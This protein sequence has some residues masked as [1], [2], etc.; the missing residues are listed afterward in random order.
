MISLQDL[1]TLAKSGWTPKATKEILE[2]V[3]TSPA[4]QD[5]V[6]EKNEDD[7]EIK[8]EEPAVEEEK[9]ETISDQNDNDLLE[10]LKNL[11]QE[12]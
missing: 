7:V 6:V 8:K 10:K 3:E 4:L 5:A 9:Q 12:E 11:L 2:M 1:V